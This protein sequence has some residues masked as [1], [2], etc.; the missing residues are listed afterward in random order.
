MSDEPII[1]TKERVG[2]YDALETAKPGEIIFALQGLDPFGPPTVLHWAKLARAAAAE[3]PDEEKREAMLRKATSAETVA[4]AMMEQ[5]RGE[6]VAPEPEEEV[7]GKVD[8]GR[9]AILVRAADRVYNF[10]AEILDIADQLA[11]V[12]D[13]PRR[14]VGLLRSAASEVKRA[15]TIFE[16]RRHLRREGAQ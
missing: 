4:W 1:S 15:V 9:L 11:A 3:E 5:Q 8:Q 10:D 14:A 6:T 13:P 7:A 16:P 2:E 12:S